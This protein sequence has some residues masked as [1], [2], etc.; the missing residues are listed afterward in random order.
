M[1][2]DLSGNR[3]TEGS[4]ENGRGHAKKMIISA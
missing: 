2:K 3:V 4:F 1:E